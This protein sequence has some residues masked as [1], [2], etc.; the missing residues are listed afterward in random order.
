MLLAVAL[1]AVAV[2]LAVSEHNRHK[3]SAALP[4]PQGSY[5]ALV[6][7]SGPRVVGRRTPCGVVIGTGTMGISSPVLPCGL[8]LYLNYRSRHV[9]ASVIGRGPAGPGAEFSVT[10]ALARKLG[11]SGVKR[12]RWSYAGRS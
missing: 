1:L 5:T 4:K 3:A 11:V 8:R 6:A 9:L 10:P 12:M 7:T 2:S